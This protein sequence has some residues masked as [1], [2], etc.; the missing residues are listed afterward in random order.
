MRYLW[1]MYHEYF[2]RTN[3][4]VHF[5]MRRLIPF[6]RLWDISS[7]NLVDHF[8]ANSGYVAKR[9]ARYYN[10]KATV[11]YPPV[12]V[13]NF[14]SVERR[15]KD[16]YLFFGQFTG[17]KRADLAI[18]AC[19]QSGRKL[20]VAG[21]GLRK[22]DEKKYQKTGLITFK[23][24]VTDAE[25]REL[26]ASAR[27]LLFPGIE[28]FGII[29]IEAQA[30]GCPVIAFREGGAVETIKEN[31]TG[32]FFDEQTPESLIAA[33]DRFEYNEVQFSGRDAFKNHVQ[34]FSKSAFIERMH[35]VLEE[36]RR[37]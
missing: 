22:K 24:R 30:S 5:F 20:L 26:Y 4:L 18:A 27:A 12:D 1:D 19:I 9:I 28:D 2:R 31:V 21:A 7:A 29:P 37:I 16:G 33:I 25:A 23:G 10:R 32:F 6:L 3:P 36:K 34:Q 14:L 35:R 13:E 15:P 17:Y 8:V 11:I